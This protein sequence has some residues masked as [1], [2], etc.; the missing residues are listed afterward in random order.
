MK[1][2]LICKCLFIAGFIIVTIGFIVIYYY[3][4]SAVELLNYSTI[5]VSIP[6]HFS[7]TFETP[8]KIVIGLGAAKT[9][10]STFNYVLHYTTR[11]ARFDP[12]PYKYIIKGETS[13]WLSC[14]VHIG[15]YLVNTYIKKLSG[16]NLDEYY[17]KVLIRNRHMDVMESDQLILME[18]TPSYLTHYNTAKMLTHYAKQY[19]NIYFYVL[20]RD[21]IKRLWSHYWMRYAKNLKQTKITVHQM[22]NIISNDLAQVK[23]KYP[24][25]MQLMRGLKNKSAMNE[26]LRLYE[27]SQTQEM[28][29]YNE[30]DMGFHCIL[31]SCYF[32]IILHWFS[33]LNSHNDYV[34]EKRF[35]I[36]QTE[37]FVEHQAE[38]IHQLLCWINGGMEYEYNASKCRQN[39]AGIPKR[40]AKYKKNIKRASWSPK[41]IDVKQLNI[42]NALAVFYG[43]CNQRLYH[44]LEMYPTSVLGKRPFIQFALFEKVNE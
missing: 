32:P 15:Q 24:L 5:T 33:L 2:F 26:I 27:A 17:H 11:V 28:T 23:T 7:S 19:Q 9:S 34:F 22:E 36:L 8:P 10:S 43:D 44:F 37:Y 18:K 20:L 6:S 1:R 29:V 35:R 21:P 30:W 25:F 14:H 13:Y 40:H 12:H 39:E 16:C 3:A 42:S 4:F 41:G 31:K 38:T